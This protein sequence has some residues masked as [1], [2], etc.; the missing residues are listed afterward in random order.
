[1]EVTAHKQLEEQLRHAQRMEAIGR[2]AGGIAHDFNNILQTITGY[3]EMLLDNLDSPL[4]RKQALRIRRAASR[5]I[6]LTGQ[7]LAYGRKRMFVPEHLDVNAV[8]RG[9]A[10]M[11]GRLIG[12]HIELVLQLEPEIGCTRMDRGGLEQIIMNLSIN[13]RDALE[14]GG[15]LT[16]RTERVTLDEGFCA[17]RVDVVPGTYVLVTATDTGIG[18]DAATQSRIFE[19]FFTTK[20]HGKGTG[21]GL[22]TVYGIIKQSGGHIEV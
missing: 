18:M 2:L 12:E 4:H 7:L 22:A 14:R 20:P 19:P 16:L 1:R 3:S 6:T 15:T 11:L 9:M 5:A 13:A 21:L 10:E 8:L 17:S